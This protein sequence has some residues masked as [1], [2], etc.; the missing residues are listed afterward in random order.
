VFSFS[1]FTLE[2]K[3]ALDFKLIKRDEGADAVIV[4]PVA[5]TASF[6]ENHA[7]DAVDIRTA[8]TR[9]MANAGISLLESFIIFLLFK[10]V[11]D[12]LY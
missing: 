2:P 9:S 7:K 1:S 4:R 6:M 5:V 12:L 8:E 10:I 3:S 11:L